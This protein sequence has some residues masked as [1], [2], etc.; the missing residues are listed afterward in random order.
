M[1]I[2]I[3]IK[4]GYIQPCATLGGRNPAPLGMLKKHLALVKTLGPRHLAARAAVLLGVSPN[5]W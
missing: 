4:H 2:F 5:G 1:K 3:P